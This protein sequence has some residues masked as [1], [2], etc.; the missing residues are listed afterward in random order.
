[1][2]YFAIPAHA[3]AIQSGQPVNMP[4]SARSDNIVGVGGD[5][6]FLF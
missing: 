3:P 6:G 4:S 5:N 2:K 1:M